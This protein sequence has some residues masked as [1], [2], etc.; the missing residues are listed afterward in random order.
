[1][2]S[3]EVYLP[4]KVHHGNREPVMKIKRNRKSRQ[5]KGTTAKI[6]G[7]PKDSKKYKDP[8]VGT[9]A[10]WI[11]TPFGPLY[12]CIRPPKTIAEGDVQ[13]LQIRARR[14][15]YLDKFR[16]RWCPDAGP[17][18]TGE[19]VTAKAGKP[20]HRT[21]YPYRC[22]VSPEQFSAAMTM[23]IFA[24]DS[25]KFKPLVDGPEGLGDPALASKLHSVY[26]RTWSTQLDLSDGTSSYDWHG[27]GG[28]GGY[29]SGNAA[30]VPVVTSKPDS[31]AP[32]AECR[33]S[34]HYFS[35]K[36]D[37]GHYECC[38]CPAV[39]DAALHTYSYPNGKDMAA[40]NKRS[41]VQY[42]PPTGYQAKLPGTGNVNYGTGTAIPTV[43]GGLV[44]NAPT[45]PDVTDATEDDDPGPE[46]ADAMSGL[47]QEDLDA[48]TDTDPGG[49]PCCQHCFTEDGVG[50]IDEDQH[51][52]PCTL[53][54]TGSY[55]GKL[56]TL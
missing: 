14:R 54:C 31:G 30:D 55:A 56:P 35:H 7:S 33:K 16:E 8:R 38:D 36:L 41:H 1:V 49:Y 20:G 32:N 19:E 17:V 34:G 4:Y 21:D 2:S 27:Q 18:L 10:L 47:S 50:C 3:D 24:I 43:L 37:S 6:G 28:Y 44:N 5:V 22:Y 29:Y 23:M 11:E 15:E 9:M 45:W 26:T 40:W 12:P 46:D 39:L 42:Q 25:E 13:T 52:E 48:A 51:T 53:G